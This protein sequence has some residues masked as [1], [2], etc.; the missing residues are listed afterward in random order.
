M[1]DDTWK[2]ISAR[3]GQVDTS[4]DT[5]PE[6]LGE[7]VEPD[8]VEIPDIDLT[9]GKTGRAAAE[10]II[11]ALARPAGAAMYATLKLKRLPRNIQSKADMARFVISKLLD[12]D[13]SELAAT[14]QEQAK[15]YVVDP[16]AGCCCAAEAIGG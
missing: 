12:R 6:N 15:I 5:A 14:A 9:D 13:A 3:R 4:G 7:G 16:R 2:R 10:A 1:R 8:D 11:D